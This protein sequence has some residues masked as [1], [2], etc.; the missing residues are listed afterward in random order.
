MVQIWLINDQEHYSEMEHFKLLF[1]YAPNFEETS[2][3]SWL[4]AIIPLI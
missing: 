1:I 3:G 2:F 4:G